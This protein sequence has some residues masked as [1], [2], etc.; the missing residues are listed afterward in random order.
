MNR[1]S[2]LT[3]RLVSCGQMA[4][5]RLDRSGSVAES[6][7]C[8]Y[9]AGKTEMEIGTVLIKWKYSADLQKLYRLIHDVMEHKIAARLRTNSV[10]GASA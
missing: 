9:Q 7:L 8:S 1:R 5:L 3:P 4:F 6:I 2:L 10:G